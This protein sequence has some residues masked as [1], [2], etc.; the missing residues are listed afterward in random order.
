MPVTFRRPPTVLL[1]TARELLTSVNRGREAAVLLI[2]LMRGWMLLRLAVW[3]RSTDVRTNY[4]HG[5]RLYNS[6]FQFSTLQSPDLSL[7]I[8]RRPACWE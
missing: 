4:G 3:S 1:K 2:V 7:P 6:P 5:A 8:D